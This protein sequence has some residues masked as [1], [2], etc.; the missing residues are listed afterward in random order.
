[1]DSKIRGTL[2]SI[3]IVLLIVQPLFDVYM[4]IIGESLDIFGISIVTLLRTTT[5][6]VLVIMTAIYQIKDR[7]KLKWLIALVIYLLIVGIY[8]TLHHFNIIQSNGY[9]ITQGLYDFGAELMYVLR[10]V[11]PVILIYTVIMIKPNKEQIEKSIISVVFIISLIIILTNLFKISYAS[12]SPINDTI[13]YNVFDWFLLSELPYEES[14]SKGFFV[15]ANQIGAL[16]AILLPIVIMYICKHNNVF[17]YIVLLLGIISMVLIGTRVGTYGFIL[18]TI[19]MCLVVILITIIKKKRLEY[20]N[21]IAIVLIMF[22]GLILYSKSPAKNRT[23]IDSSD[24]MYSELIDDVIDTEECITLNNFKEMLKDEIRIKEYLNYELNDSISGET[25]RYEAMCKYIKENHKY[26]SITRKYVMK[27][28]PYE[29]DPEF[30]LN[31]FEQPASVKGD[32]RAKQSVIIK[33][34]KELNDNQV[35]DTLLGMGATPMNSREYMIENDLISHYYNI[36]II[37]IILFVAPYAAVIVYVAIL[38]LKDL[39]YRLTVRLSAYILSIFMTYGIGYFAGHVIDEYIVTIYVA[40]IAGLA[41][42]HINEILW[43]E[44]NE[45]NNA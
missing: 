43:G 15:S 41:I 23:F 28:Y 14:L 8:I 45:R 34:I 31:L 18:V 33:H 42:N 7:Y 21:I 32:N 22:A 9:F 4:A 44:T 17:T 6:V 30:W 36:G 26:H 35:Y 25:L 27:I 20:L 3:L 24:D 13:S 37:G 19:A 10:L 5:C 38:V 11:V 2:G 16:L 1:M 12:Y 40:T 29:Q 39:K